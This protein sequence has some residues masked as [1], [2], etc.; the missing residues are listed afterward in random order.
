MP[1]NP[2]SGTNRAAS[3][4][5][6]VA[7]PTG[8]RSPLPSNAGRFE[9]NWTGIA[10]ERN[11]GRA[12][13]HVEE[14]PRALSSMAGS[15]VALTWVVVGGITP[16]MADG[17]G[18]VGPVMGWASGTAGAVLRGPFGSGIITGWRAGRQPQG[19]E[20]STARG[21]ASGVQ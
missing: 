4:P 19:I 20:P 12:Q 6:D 1:G 8:L 3:S 17:V 7:G 18:R 15:G 16:R 14:A 2:P 9:P 10:V 11:A 13:P 21:A 5:E